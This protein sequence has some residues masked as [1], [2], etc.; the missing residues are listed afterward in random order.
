M[1]FLDY[2]GNGGLDPQDIV[3][4]VVI[5]ETAPKAEEADSPQRLEN[6]AGCATMAAFIAL[7]ILIILL[8]L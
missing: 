7:P 6:N 3:T 8:A 1:K 4:S 2:N 5:E